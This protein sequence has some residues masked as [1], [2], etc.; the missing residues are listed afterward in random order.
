MPGW[1]GSIHE[2]L[3]EEQLKTIE[4]S[5]ADAPAGLC[6]DKRG[7]PLNRYP[8]MLTDLERNDLD[9]YKV[10]ASERPVTERGMILISI[11]PIPEMPNALLRIRTDDEHQ[12]GIPG[13]AN[14]SRPGQR[15]EDLQ[16]KTTFHFSIFEPEATQRR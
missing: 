5:L 12:Q 14:A 4:K 11:T 2:L 3:T 15:E 6:V 1:R 9:G 8:G 16:K 7:L 10:V 13:R